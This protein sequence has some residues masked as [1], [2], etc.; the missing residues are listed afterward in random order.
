MT[1]YASLPGSATT[2]DPVLAS[3]HK[4]RAAQLTIAGFLVIVFSLVGVNILGI[5]IHGQAY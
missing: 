1:F 3:Q 5:G 4:V 2:A